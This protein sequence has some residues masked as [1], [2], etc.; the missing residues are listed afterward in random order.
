MGNELQIFEGTTVPQVLADKFNDLPLALQEMSEDE[1]R[2]EYDYTML[3]NR[4]RINLWKEIADNFNTGKPLVMS[5]VFEGVCSRNNF[6]K[7]TNTPHKLAFLMSPVQDY[8]EKAETLLEIASSRYIDILKMDIMTTKRTPIGIDDEGKIK[9]GIK[10]DVDPFKAKLLL[11]TIANLENRVKGSSVQKSI[12]V[13]DSKPKDA[14]VDTFDVSA[15][16]DKLNELEG[17]L[18]SSNIDDASVVDATF[19]EVD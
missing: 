10:T 13:H 19:K 9:Y 11:D 1:L 17:K 18:Q 2:K 3:E 14:V 4:V 8:N 5:R 6:Y 7:I 12:T 16:Q 15:I